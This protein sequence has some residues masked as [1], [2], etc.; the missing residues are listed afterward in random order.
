MQHPHWF[1][2]PIPSTFDFATTFSCKIFSHVNKYNMFTV[3]PKT[4]NLK[5][6]YYIPCNILIGLQV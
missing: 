1:A 5:M 6:L 2:S 3:S 4:I